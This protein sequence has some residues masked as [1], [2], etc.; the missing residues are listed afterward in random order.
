MNL[1]LLNKKWVVYKHTAP[2]GKIY[3]GITNQNPPTKRWSGGFGYET[4]IYF[5]RA[6]VKY[7]W[8][9]F[10]HEILYKDLTKKEAEDIETKLIKKYNTTDINYGYNIDA[11]GASHLQCKEV[12]N[13]IK[14]SKTG[15]KWSER[16]RVSHLDYIEHHVGRTVYKYDRNGTLITSFINVTL[17]AKDAGVPTETLRTYLFTQVPKTFNYVYSYNNFIEPKYTEYKDR[18]W[19]KA[20]VDMFD[21]SLKYI[22]TFE[23]IAEA[24]RFLGVKGTG[25]ICDVCKGKRLSCNGYIWRYHNE[26]TDIKSA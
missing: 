5:W 8:I 17:A 18:H 7:G 16:Q 26:N 20:S 23:S 3:I 4:Q 9:N 21:M 12:R 19:N 10:T 25:H 2:N 24:S 6:I 13:K 22:R 14:E 15:K 11:G 1:K